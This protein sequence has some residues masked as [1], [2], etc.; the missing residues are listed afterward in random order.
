MNFLYLDGT[1]ES[2]EAAN[3]L[4]KCSI[5]VKIINVKE[6]QP[7]EIK[8]PYLLT[9]EDCYVSLS[10]VKEYAESRGCRIG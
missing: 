8:P 3:I 6:E 7:I 5:Q 10:R 1:E 9:P 2:K 4:Q